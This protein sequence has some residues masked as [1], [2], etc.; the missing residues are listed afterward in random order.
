MR[1]LLFGCVLQHY[2]LLSKLYRLIERKNDLHQH[3][4]LDDYYLNITYSILFWPSTQ[5]QRIWRSTVNLVSVT[6]HAALYFSSGHCIFIKEYVY[7]MKVSFNLFLLETYL[8]SVYFGL[9]FKHIIWW[10]S[11]QGFPYYLVD[12]LK[13]SARFINKLD[14]FIRE[15]VIEFSAKA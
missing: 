15:I 11:D 7:S 4:Q 8:I 6:W 5:I 14:I 10:K 12:Y 1:I 3:Y 13:C 2:L 9:E